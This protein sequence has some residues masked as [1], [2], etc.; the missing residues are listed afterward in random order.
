VFFKDGNGEIGL[1]LVEG[2]D[3]VGGELLQFAAF[4]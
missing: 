1:F 4:D 3:F 2:L